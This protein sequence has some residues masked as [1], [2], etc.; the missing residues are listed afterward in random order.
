MLL[1]CWSRAIRPRPHIHTRIHTGVGP[2]E[3]VCDS[4]R[5]ERCRQTYNPP[6]N[7]E[8]Q[9]RNSNPVTLDNATPHRARADTS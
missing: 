7:R 1:R 3:R 2:Q 4:L 8:L 6:R 9:N 5:L